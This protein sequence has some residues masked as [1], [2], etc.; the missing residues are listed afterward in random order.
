[1]IEMVFLKYVVDSV[2]RSGMITI[3][4]EYSSTLLTIN[5]H[6]VEFSD[7]D[8]RKHVEGNPRVLRNI[9]SY[10]RNKLLYQEYNLNSLQ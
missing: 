5:Y 2:A 1:M 7:N 3:E 9:D 10:L 4:F 8:L 6:D